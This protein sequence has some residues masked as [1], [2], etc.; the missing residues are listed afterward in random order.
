MVVGGR[1]NRLGVE[2]GGSDQG[3]GS[4]REAG[5]VGVGEVLNYWY[6][7]ISYRS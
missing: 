2:G 5:I 1:N 7:T 3:Q 4:T 6:T